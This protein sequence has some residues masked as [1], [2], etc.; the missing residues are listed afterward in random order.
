MRLNWSSTDHLIQIQ[1]VVRA[2]GQNIGSTQL[3]WAGDSRFTFGAEHQSINTIQAGFIIKSLTTIL[4]FGTFAL[5]V[6]S[7]PYWDPFK[8]FFKGAI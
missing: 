4:S 3:P 6:A 8:S 7:T 5:A 2:D 1:Q